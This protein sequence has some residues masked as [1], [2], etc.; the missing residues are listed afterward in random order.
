[1][2]SLIRSS[3]CLAISAVAIIGASSIQAQGV[4]IRKDSLFTAEDGLDVVTYTALD[5]TSDGRWLAATSASR[6]DGL[7]VDY[8]HDGDPTYVRPAASRM[9]VI[10]TKSGTARPLFPE[11]R[12]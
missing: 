2:R 11:K 1:M 4:A 5:L 8:R 7:G 6:R 10:D 9:W 3:T 12:N